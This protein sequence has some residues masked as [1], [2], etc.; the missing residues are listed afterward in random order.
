MKRGWDRNTQ[1]AANAMGRKPC[2]ASI[3][4]WHPPS[5]SDSKA[6][7]CDRFPQ[8]GTEVTAATCDTSGVTPPTCDS[9]HLHIQH[10]QHTS[11]HAS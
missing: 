7:Q 6:A 9:T 1:R 10:G 2:L 5:N 3:T 8:G 11:V 4:R